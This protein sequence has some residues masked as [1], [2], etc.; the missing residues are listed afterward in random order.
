MNEIVKQKLRII[1]SLL[2]FLTFLISLL[3][4]PE[5]RSEW[6]FTVLFFIFSVGTFLEYY[7][8]RKKRK[9]KEYRSNAEVER[10]SGRPRPESGRPG[11]K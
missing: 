6:I 3:R 11:R 10:E 2:F 7:S 9:N 5:T 4:F 8:I 1:L